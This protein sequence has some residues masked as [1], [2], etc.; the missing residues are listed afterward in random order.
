[1]EGDDDE[2]EECTPSSPRTFPLSG[3]LYVVAIDWADVFLF[4]SIFRSCFAIP[5]WLSHILDVQIV[6]SLN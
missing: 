5:W 2:D 3:I 1:M 6:I 4:V